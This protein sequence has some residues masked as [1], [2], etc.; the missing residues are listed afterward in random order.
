MLRYDEEMMKNRL[1]WLCFPLSPG[2]MGMEQ[3]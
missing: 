2:T 3:V 1:S